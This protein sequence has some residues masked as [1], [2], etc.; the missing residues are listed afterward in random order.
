M[1]IGIKMDIQSYLVQEKKIH[2][3]DSI[4]HTKMDIIDTSMNDIKGDY[5]KCCQSSWLA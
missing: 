3:I 4:L 1:L 2:P 5:T